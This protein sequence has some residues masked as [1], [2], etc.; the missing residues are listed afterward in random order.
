MLCQVILGSGLPHSMTAP[1]LL[2]LLLKSA[3]KTFCWLQG[4]VQQGQSSQHAVLHTAA[5]T[6]HEA[7]QSDTAQPQRSSM[8]RPATPLLILLHSLAGLLLLRAAAAHCGACCA[9]LGPA[10]G[11]LLVCRH[12]VWKQEQQPCVGTKHP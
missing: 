3:C 5:H 11:L 6:L 12:P 10:C 9:A 7:V 2:V 8:M 4:A 1:R